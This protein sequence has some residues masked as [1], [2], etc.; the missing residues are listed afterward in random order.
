MKKT[1]SMLL[2]LL[3]IAGSLLS[4]SESE[5]KPDLPA[6][7]PAASA[8]TEAVPEAETEYSRA[9]VPDNLPQLDFNGA[10][11]V[12]H[13]RGDAEALTEIYSEELNGEA[14][15]DAIFERNVSVEERLNVSIGCFAGDG[16]ENYDNTVSAIRSSIMSADG[17]YDIVA[18]WSSRIPALSLEGLFLDLNE[19]NYLDPEQNWWS[20]SAIREL[21]VGNRL[22]FV[23]GDIARSM[24]SS[25][26]VYV[27]NQKVAEDNHVEN[28]YDVVKEHRWTID[29]VYDLSSRIYKDLNGN[30]Q[31]DKSDFWGL[32]TSCINDADAYMQGSL[33]SMMSRDEEGWPVLSVDEEQ[34]ADLVSKVYRLDWDN[35]GCFANPDGETDI[36]NTIAEDKALL[37]S[38]RLTAV[39]GSLGDMESDYG[40]LPYPML[41]E[42][43]ESYGTR[44]QDALSLWCIP[45]DAKD[46]D[47][48]AAVMEALA[49]ESWRKVTPAY[50]D[51]ALKSRYS[52]D[53]ETSAMMD[54]I[55]DSVL[56]NFESLYNRAIGQPWFVLRN[57]MP[58]K[59]KN[60]SSYWASNKKLLAKNVDKAIKKLTELD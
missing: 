58:Q 8:P 48:S 7:D 39:V 26:C 50:F 42:A 32:V 28:L 56:I 34:L 47:L 36:R 46:P 35:P 18:G 23:T 21:Q 40:V 6:S 41:N 53:P 27:F 45:I 11:V 25:L 33:V 37:A 19:M 13:S 29:H 3:I 15:N 44:V 16:W 49:A 52:R 12:I 43:Q 60:F 4:C 54:L 10:S 31:A 1:V 30:G 14:V 9:N 2:T 17:A 57:L 59:D 22:Y 24:L 55:K 51:V 20:A 38:T 5:Q